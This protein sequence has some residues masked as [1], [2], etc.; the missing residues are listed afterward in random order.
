MRCD[1]LRTIKERQE[2]LQGLDLRCTANSV[3][4]QGLNKRQWEMCIYVYISE[5]TENKCLGKTTILRKF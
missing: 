1:L 3:C 2:Q 5:D 4:R